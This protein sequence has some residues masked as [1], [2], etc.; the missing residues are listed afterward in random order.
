MSSGLDDRVYKIAAD[1]VSLLSAP[2]RL[3]I[4]CALMEGE[5]NV[6]EL[7]DCVALSRPDISPPNM[8][9]HPGAFHR[10]G[11]LARRRAKRLI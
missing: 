8:S 1:L 4:V 6:T 10:G 3:R 7:I 5:M 9:H 11:V 2:T